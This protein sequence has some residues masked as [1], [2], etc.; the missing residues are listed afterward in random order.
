M[1]SFSQNFIPFHIKKAQRVET[2]MRP[3]GVPWKCYTQWA[4]I[5]WF[6]RIPVH[7]KFH[8]FKLFQIC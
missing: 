7:Q 8:H 6:E 4:Y 1:K 2:F 5:E 3:R